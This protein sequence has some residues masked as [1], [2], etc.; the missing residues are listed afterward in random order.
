MQLL[1]P[2]TRAPLLGGGNPALRD[3]WLERLL[4]KRTC[5]GLVAFGKRQ[6]LK[7]KEDVH[8]G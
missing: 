3:D 7:G 5:N 4:F 1:D 8:V 6:P 2:P